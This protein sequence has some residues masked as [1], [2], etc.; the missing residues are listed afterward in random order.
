[1]CLK[2]RFN[3]QVI[4]GVTYFV[5]RH[6][7]TDEIYEEVIK[8]NRGVVNVSRSTVERAIRRFVKANGPIMTLAHEGDKEFEKKH[9]PK[10]T[11]R[12][13]GP[14]YRWIWD[15]RP[16]AFLVNNDG[17]I[18][19]VIASAIEDA[20]SGYPIDCSFIPR[21]EEFTPKV[22][23]TVDFISL[24]AR[25]QLA[26]AMDDHGIRSLELYTDN[27]P[28]FRKELQ[29]QLDV[30]TRVSTPYKVRHSRPGLPQGRG[31]IE[32]FLHL[33]DK[34]LRKIP[35]YI[36]EDTFERV[37]EVSKGPLLTFEQFVERM[38]IE[39]E[40]LCN[41]P[42]RKGEKQTREA[43]W[44]SDRQ[45]TLEAPS[46]Q[47]LIVFANTLKQYRAK[48]YGRGVYRE[49]AYFVPVTRTLE[50]ETLLSKLEGQYVPLR[51]VMRKDEIVAYACL[52]GQQWLP[53][54]P[55]EMSQDDTDEF[56]EFRNAARR[57]IKKAN[58]IMLDDLDTIMK[59][60]HTGDSL[61]DFLQDSTSKLAPTELAP[62]DDGED[63]QPTPEEPRV[64]ADG[65]K[66]AEEVP[67]DESKSEEG[68]AM[69][70]MLEKLRQR[71][72]KG[73]K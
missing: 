43:L 16:L 56:M 7:D 37:R 49:N 55:R 34:I 23:E 2:R 19:R 57:D 10:K 51:L 41:K 3:E 6:A 36:E 69:A 71:F 64:E 21:K 52:D 60:T 32:K 40:K 17:V 13:P 42:P 58:R 11:N 39:I 68:A 54:Q 61:D 72:Q 67:A 22:E 24:T 28:V 29:S 1:M 26:G 73:S 25:R 38:K 62:T 4:D 65:S 33:L 15:M 66:A 53:F 30:L 9:Q 5:I 18:C 50:T 46:E 48:I 45:Y 20:F 35:G 14:N 59:E 12:V 70:A 63:V 47:R 8:A 31:M 27:G 44:K